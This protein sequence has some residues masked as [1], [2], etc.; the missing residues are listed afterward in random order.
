MKDS[1]IRVKVTIE[2]SDGVLHFI[3]DKFSKVAFKY[4]LLLSKGLKPTIIL[5]KPGNSSGNF[6]TRKFEKRLKAEI[7][8][9]S[10]KFIVIRGTR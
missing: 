6:N 2:T 8:N 5:A 9:N 1:N 10:D 7:K 3:S 4:S